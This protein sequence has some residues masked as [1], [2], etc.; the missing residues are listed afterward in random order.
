MLSLRWRLALL[1][2]AI[3]LAALAVIYLYVVP[4]LESSLRSEKQRALS[5][6][7]RV[8]SRP[9]LHAVAADAN[10]RRV[11]AFVR[12]AADRSGARVTLLG[13]SR[14]T[15][16]IQTY[17][18]AD[19]TTEQGLADLQFQVAQE[20]AQSGHTVSGS[21]PTNNGRIAEAARPIR[22]G[23]RVSR[24]VVYSSSLSDV[25]STVELIRRRILIAG[26]IALAIG[27]LG[28]F[29][30]ARALAR[31]VKR[32]ELAAERVAGGD[33]SHPIPVESSDEIG[34]L[35]L[36][37]NEMQRQLAQLDSARK[38]F[39]ATASHELRTPVHSLGGFV[40]L[41]QDEDLD[42]EDRQ[43]F[44]DQIAEQVDRLRNLSV[45][46]LDLS[47]LEAGSLE[48]HPEPTD[49]G[50]LAR[51]VSAEFTPFAAQHRSDVDVHVGE[52]EIEANCDPDRVA[53]IVRILLDN[54]LTHTPQGTN[55]EVSA[56]RENGQVSLAVQDH[57]LGIKRTVL[58][59]VFEP[60]YTSDD[61]QGSGLGLAIARELAERMDGRLA[62]ES[63][64]GRT[65][66][67]LELPA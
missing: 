40:E 18:I 34:E 65:T 3:L 47:K 44:L 22:M 38:R 20:A 16:G 27:V 30:V 42:E 23:G 25:Q 12:Q 41:L 14:G 9:L 56:A 57:G 51:S 67:T 19:S 17:P 59:R 28:G 52:E 15:L 6:N 2:L 63:V 53:Q 29:L 50:K 24:V 36:A 61:A 35:A 21:E 43:A 46:L 1:F 45:D 48:L 4:Q 55:I 66:F 64:P 49:V 13:V 7:A 11:R 54:A 31:R 5:V 37:F 39:I 33:F 26:G 62:V 10:A 60:F 32:L 58:P 8:Y